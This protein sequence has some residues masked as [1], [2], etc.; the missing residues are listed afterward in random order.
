MFHVPPFHGPKYGDGSKP[1]YLVNP[2]IAGKWMFIPLKMVFIGI[3]PYPYVISCPTIP[4]V[5]HGI[6]LVFLMQAYICDAAASPLA[7][8]NDMIV[9]RWASTPT[10]QNPVGPVANFGL[11]SL[12]FY[13]YRC[14]MVFWELCGALQI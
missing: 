4:W 5:F 9:G 2:K 11:L 12:V 3:D 8:N 14:S 7:M 6:S 10:G 13:F 1:W